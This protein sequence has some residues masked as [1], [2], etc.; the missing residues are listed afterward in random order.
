MK[1]NRILGLQKYMDYPSLTFRL[2][3]IFGIYIALQS[4]IADNPFRAAPL[5][6][7][8]SSI[9]RWGYPSREVNSR[10]SQSLCRHKWL[11]AALPQIVILDDREITR[12]ACR[13]PELLQGRGFRGDVPKQGSKAA[14]S[15]GALRARGTGH[16]LLVLS[17]WHHV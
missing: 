6:C 7:C 5:K 3:I 13:S 8:Y 10:I 16:I 4:G 9:C 11:A 15:V 14:G 2:I 12:E 17:Q 1:S